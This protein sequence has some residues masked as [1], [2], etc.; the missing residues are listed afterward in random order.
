M[1]WKCPRCDA[2]QTQRV[3]EVYAQGVAAT[4]SGWAGIATDGRQAQVGVGGGKSETISELANRLKPPI[5][6][7]GSPWK[8]AGAIGTCLGGFVAV[9]GTDQTIS[10]PAGVFAGALAVVLIGLLL[11]RSHETAKQQHMRVLRC[12]KAQVYCHRCGMVFDGPDVEEHGV[13]GPPQRSS[14]E[15]SATRRAEVDAAI[16]GLLGQRKNGE[17]GDNSARPI[18]HLSELEVE[19]KSKG[20]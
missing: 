8:V 6:P 19:L 15:Q 10:I 3:S 17:P 5:F 13:L 7:Q 2:D 14:A 4:T 11:Q 1:A 20:Q 12:W 16:E 18:R 9:V